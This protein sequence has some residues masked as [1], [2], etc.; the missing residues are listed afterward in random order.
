MDVP[1]MRGAC[2]DFKNG[3]MLPGDGSVLL[4]PAFNI[5]NRFSQKNVTF[6]ACLFPYNDRYDG[7]NNDRHDGRSGAYSVTRM[8]FKRGKVH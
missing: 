1:V 6:W 5:K 4:K 8:V 7:R 2:P 3:S